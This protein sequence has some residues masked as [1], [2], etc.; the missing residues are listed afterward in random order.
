MTNKARST[1]IRFVR[2]TRLW[3]S[4]TLARPAVRNALRRETLDALTD[5]CL[6]LRDD[7]EL[8]LVT[9][10]GEGSVF[11][12][13]ADL[14]ERSGLSTGETLAF[15]DAFR[16]LVGLIERLPCVSAAVLQ[17]AALGGGLELVL[18]CDFVYAHER[19]QLGLPEV[20]LGIIP[21][22][23]GTQRLQRRV[24][25]VG[26]QRRMVLL[27][28]RLNAHEALAAG[29]VDKVA[30]DSEQLGD[31]VAELASVLARQNTAAVRA[32]KESMRG[33]LVDEA[34]LDLER[35]CYRQLLASPARAAALEAFTRKT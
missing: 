21:G 33:R 18:G 17:G 25:H 28:E 3:A 29:L 26:L 13:G 19:T 5:A 34:G 30:K 11:C 7:P 9:F 2:E 35:A 15:L 8:N 10:H 12:A 1:D 23:G 31:M 14:K 16:R 22:A 6:A 20:G 24:P 32:A 27:G 4:I